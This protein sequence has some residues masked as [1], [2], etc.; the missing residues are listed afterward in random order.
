MP[1]IK[2]FIT[3][4]I[5]TLTTARRY[6]MEASITKLHKALADA[7]FQTEKEDFLN[8]YSKAHEK[9]RLIRYGELREITNAV[10]VSETLC[11]LGHQVKVDH[12]KLRFALDVF[13]EDYIDTL[14]LRPYAKKLLKKASKNCKLG[15]I[16]NFTYAPV[17]HKSMK[18]LGIADY[19]DVVI[20]SQECGWRKPHGKIFQDALERL[21]CKAEETV[22][23]G[24][25]P[26]EDIKGALEAGLKTVFVQSQFYDMHDLKASSLNP[27]VIAK[28]LKEVYANFAEITNR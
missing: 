13:F 18:Q 15:L 3:D 19:F 25:C 27:Q 7:G 20:V 28:D 6:T 5:G 21:K 2:A 10:W 9:Y 11:E 16:S 26:L 12:E 23:L 22:F 4:Y 1:K 17:V 8:A 14:Q 24:D